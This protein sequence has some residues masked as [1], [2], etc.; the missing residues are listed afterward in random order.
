MY[1]VV[2]VSGVCKSSWYVKLLKFLVSAMFLIS[3]IVDVP[4]VCTVPDVKVIDG[5]GV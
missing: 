5:P 1:K 4:G 3:E 2:G